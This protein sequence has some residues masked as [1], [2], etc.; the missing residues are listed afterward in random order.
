MFRLLESIKIQDGR[1]PLLEYHQKRMKQCMAEVF[2]VG[3]CPDLS[4]YLESRIPSPEGSFKARLVYDKEIRECGV[5]PYVKREITCLRLVVAELDY[6]R[7]YENREAFKRLMEKRN[8]DE[9]I[10]I[11]KNGLRTAVSAIWL[12]LTVDTGIRPGTA[13]WPAYAVSP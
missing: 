6:E 4:H 5:L 11:V 10:I 1:M 3:D 2:G 7:K 8:A 13:F 9:E 12:F